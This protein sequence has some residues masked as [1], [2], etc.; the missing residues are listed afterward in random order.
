LKSSRQDG[1]ETEKTAEKG[2]K[3]RSGELGFG[4]ARAF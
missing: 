3:N 2:K 4:A 1:T